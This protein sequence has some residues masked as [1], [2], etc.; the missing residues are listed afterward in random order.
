MSLLQK[1]FISSIIK[2]RPSIIIRQKKATL[3]FIFI[4]KRLF[5]RNTLNSL[6]E[7]AKDATSNKPE[8]YVQKWFLLNEKYR[9]DDFIIE[10]KF[11][12]FLLTQGFVKTEWQGKFLLSA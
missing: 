12:K 11:K 1:R 5:F 2:R 8:R 4:Q 7:S 9:G 10:T 3:S 6:V